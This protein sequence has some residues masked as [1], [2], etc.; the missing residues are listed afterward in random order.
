MLLTSGE[1]QNFVGIHPSRE[2]D[3]GKQG[4]FAYQIGF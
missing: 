3:E 1:I 2:E 4:K